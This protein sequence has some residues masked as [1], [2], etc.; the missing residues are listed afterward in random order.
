MVCKFAQIPPDIWMTLP[1]DAKKILL[2]E[3]KLQQ[4]ED[5]KIKKSLA[6]SK[7]LITRKLTILICQINMQE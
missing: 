6:F 5:D 7:H 3:R 2:N 1:L 4:Q